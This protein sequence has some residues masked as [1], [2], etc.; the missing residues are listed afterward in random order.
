[1]FSTGHEDVDSDTSTANSTNT[2]RSSYGGYYGYNQD[3]KV[4]TGSVSFNLQP[5]DSLSLNTRYDIRREL[6]KKE[7][8]N[9]LGL[10]ILTELIHHTLINRLATRQSKKPHRKQIVKK[11]IH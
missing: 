7:A 3:E 1:M 9:L 11:F 4:D 8:D 2:S 5:F 10:I 6:E